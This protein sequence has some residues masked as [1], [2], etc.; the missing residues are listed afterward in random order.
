LLSSAALL[1]T[2]IEGGFGIFEENV[3]LE[4][5]FRKKA[6]VISIF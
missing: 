6:F 5:D 3:V 1:K 4:F 2:K